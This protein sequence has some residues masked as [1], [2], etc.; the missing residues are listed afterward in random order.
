[1][2][3]EVE[4]ALAAL[5]VASFRIQEALQE[6]KGHPV[7]INEELLILDLDYAVVTIDVGWLR[8]K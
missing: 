1:M 6:L 7:L 2:S 3:T 4:D 8:G 5:K